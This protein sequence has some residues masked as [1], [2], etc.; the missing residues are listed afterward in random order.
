MAPAAPSLGYTAVKVGIRLR[1]RNH[2]L[3]AI[4]TSKE[5]PDV[6]V[7]RQLQ[8]LDL[9]SQCLMDLKAAEQ[10]QEPDQHTWVQLSASGVSLN[11]TDQ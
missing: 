7:Q 10:F 5:S 9:I 1:D 4:L 6:T 2:F 8:H 3:A 11:S